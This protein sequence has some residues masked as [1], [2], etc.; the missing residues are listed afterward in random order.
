M[1]S[2]AWL[3]LRNISLADR[4]AGVGLR[5]LVLHS[6]VH[7]MPFAKKG[8]EKI[9]LKAVV[10]VCCRFDLRRKLFS[11]VRVCF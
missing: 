4:L 3:N 10:A 6:A 11:Y 8:S 5:V 9:N 2:A 1:R 7:K